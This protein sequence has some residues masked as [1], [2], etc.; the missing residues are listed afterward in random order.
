MSDILNTSRTAH[1]SAVQERIE[2]VGELKDVES[3]TKQLFAL[4]KETAKL[5]HDSFALKQKVALAAEVKSVLDA[6]VRHEAQVREAEQAELV[7]TVLK[8][9]QAQLG[10]KKLQKDI[11][12]ASVAEI[13]G[14][15]QCSRRR[16]EGGALRRRAD[17]YFLLRCCR[18]RQVQ[19]HLSDRSRTSLGLCPIEQP[20]PKHREVRMERSGCLEG[21][22]APRQEGWTGVSKQNKVAMQ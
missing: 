5:E 13:E 16:E 9:V 15:S 7:S 4:S 14:Q 1:T 12:L 10:D 18:P 6:W 19:G 3:L 20:E 2:S 8:N 22:R 11:L 17:L 21:R